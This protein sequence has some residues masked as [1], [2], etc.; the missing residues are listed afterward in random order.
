VLA[1]SQRQRG[2]QSMIDVA[3]GLPS[4]QASDG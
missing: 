1:G 4:D 3:R 2:W